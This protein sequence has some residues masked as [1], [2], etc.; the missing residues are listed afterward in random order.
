MATM[1]TRI[2]RQTGRPV[3]VGSAV[4]LGLDPGDHGE[5]K[6][7]T[8]CD[9]HAHCIGHE[10][11]RLALAHSSDPLGWCEACM[12]EHEW[13]ERADAQF[14]KEMGVDKWKLPYT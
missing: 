6:W 2:A 11:L 1:V 8:I 5:T 3:T 13:G 14:R 9:D 4:D 10:T 7:Y 12:E